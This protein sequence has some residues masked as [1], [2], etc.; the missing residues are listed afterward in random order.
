MSFNNA[1]SIKIPSLELVRYDAFGHSYVQGQ[2]NDSGTAFVDRFKARQG[3]GTYSNRGANGTR[4]DEML[5]SIIA[6]HPT[7]TRGLV[8]FMGALND[9][10]AYLDV[11]GAT[12]TKECFR[13]CL[14]YLTSRAILAKTDPGFVYNGTWASGASSTVGSYVDFSFTGDGAYVLFAYVTTTGGTAT[15]T[16]VAGSTTYANVT[17]GSYKQ[18]FNGAVKVAGLGA[19]SHTVRITVASGTITMV[20]ATI[21]SANP[22]IVLWCKEGS[23]PALEAIPTSKAL[24]FNNYHPA[25]AAVVPDFPTCITVPVGAGWDY[26]TMIGP[27]LV[28][29]NQKGHAYLAQQM[30]LALI[31]QPF[32]QGL[33]LMTALTSGTYATPVTATDDF[34]VDGSLSGAAMLT[35]PLTWTVSASNTFTKSGGQVAF[36]GTATAPVEAY[37]TEPALDGTLSVKCI[38]APIAGHLYG[39]GFRHSNGAD[40]Y[41]FYWDS[42]ANYLLRKRTGAGSFT[43]LVTAPATAPV[44]GETLSV[45]LSGS[46]IICK[47]NGTTVIS[48]TDITQTGTRKGLWGFTTGLAGTTWDDFSWVNA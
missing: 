33:N 19:G 37:I 9:V 16:N 15:I 5:V 39:L 34:A 32:V 4:T 27:D 23:Y 47:V 26:T 2:N 14:A 12:T 31:N 18:N 30:E 8:S 22:P 45:V 25:M 7:D 1:R 20:G 11:A 35:G 42:S 48:T 3:L 21:V 13:S 41:V 38:T 40:G 17:T 10:G 36:A 46:S 6:N 28:H 44:G 24:L 43:T 29:P